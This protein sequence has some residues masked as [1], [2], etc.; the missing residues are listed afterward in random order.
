LIDDV[1]RKKRGDF[2]IFSMNG[3]LIKELVPQQWQT[4]G[5]YEYLFEPTTNAGN[6][7]FAVLTTAEE[8]ISKKMIFIK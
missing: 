7:Y 2:E 5:N 6:I 1:V 4:T 8:V 3:S